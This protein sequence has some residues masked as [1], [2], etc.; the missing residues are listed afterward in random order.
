MVQ[1]SIIEQ[2]EMN[3]IAKKKLSVISILAG[4]AGG[5][6]YYYFTGC[7][8]GTCIITSNPIIT[9]LYGA[10]MGWLLLGTFY[11]GDSKA[12]GSDI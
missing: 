11:S 10:A 5:Y 12:K 3:I 4:A 9:M 6:L 1:G 7:N 2:K 8:T